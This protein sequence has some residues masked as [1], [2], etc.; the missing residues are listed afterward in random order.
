[1]PAEPELQSVERILQRYASSVNG[2]IPDP[3]GM[4]DDSRPPPL[5]NDLAMYVDRDYL[6]APFRVQLVVKLLYR[7]HLSP[8]DA[9]KELGCSR[10]MVYELE[11][12]ALY[13]FLGTFASNGILARFEQRA[14]RDK[15][16]AEARAR[17]AAGAPGAR[18][19]Q[20]EQSAEGE[21][22]SVAEPAEARR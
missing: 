20:Q 6:R 4:T 15:R 9:A 22:G 3:R 11:R 21:A 10:Q 19:V 2:G 5:P 17:A 12:R 8:E 18:Q 7:K 13:Y 1:M 14:A 16:Q